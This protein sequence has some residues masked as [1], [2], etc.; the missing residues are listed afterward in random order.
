MLFQ[1]RRIHFKADWFIGND[2][3][4]S[5]PLGIPDFSTIPNA[6]RDPYGLFYNPERSEGSL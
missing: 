4:P 1:N 6:V 2:R 3:D 5:L